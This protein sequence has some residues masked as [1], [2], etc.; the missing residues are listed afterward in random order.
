[1]N[2]PFIDL[3]QT[4][5]AVKDVYL[6]RVTSLLEKNR[7]ILTEEVA[8]FEQEWAEY[9]EIAHAIGVSNGSDA[10]Y[11][12]L[13][14]LGIGPGDEVITQGN[15]Y[16]ASVVAI[17]RTGA[18]P[19]FVDI[20][21]N[22]LTMNPELIAGC[23]TH[24]TEAILVVHLFGQ[25]CDIQSVRSIAD[26]HKLFLVEDCAQ[27]HG[28]MYA[29]KHTGAWGDIAA[30]SFY[31]TKNLGAFGDAGAVVTHRADLA[32]RVIRLRNL[33]SVKKNNHEIL[34]FNMRLD[35]MQAIVLSLKIPFLKEWTNMRKVAAQ[36]YSTLLADAGVGEILQGLPNG[37]HVYHLYVIHVNRR[38]AVKA[39][40]LAKGVQTEIH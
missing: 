22:T 13:L 20:V 24:K 21:P 26:A 38:D 6:E 2:V 14:A 9:L 34:G 17:L 37:T 30:F 18:T 28:A 27:S 11:L 32:E 8:Q 7:F 39:A 5:A 4:T 35:P 33:G 3:S 25:P 40:L 36:R 10:L 23:I 1:M 15:A 12:S 16:N 29:G 31:P 19:R